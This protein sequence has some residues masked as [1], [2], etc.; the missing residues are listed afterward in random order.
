MIDTR[1]SQALPPIDADG[2]MQD[3][4]LWTER[5]ATTIARLDGLQDLTDTHWQVIGYLRDHYLRYGTLPVMRHVCLTLHQ[6]RHCIDEL[7]HSPREAWRIAGL[8]NPGEEA[9]SYM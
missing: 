8:P 6:D 1:Q 9:K 3:P 2:F 5:I 7:F 4:M